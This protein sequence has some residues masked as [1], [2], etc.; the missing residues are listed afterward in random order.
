MVRRKSS[1]F[2]LFLSVMKN[3]EA[4]RCVLSIIMD[5]P[6]LTLTHV[7]VEEVILNHVGKRAI[8]LDAVAQDTNQVRYATEMQNDTDHDSMQK[9]PVIIRDFWIRRI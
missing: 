1:D 8:R 9:R 2:A 6:A 7:H 5:D 4:H 3:R